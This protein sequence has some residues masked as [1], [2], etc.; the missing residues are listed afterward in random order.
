MKYSELFAEEKCHQ[1][2]HQANEERVL[3]GFS[4]H[5]ILPARLVS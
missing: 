5:V 2:C 4:L 3:R 1:E